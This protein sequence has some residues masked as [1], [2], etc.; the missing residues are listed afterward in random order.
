M[1]GK[2]EKSEPIRSIVDPSFTVTSETLAPKSSSKCTVSACPFSAAICR[3]VMPPSAFWFTTLD[4]ALP[5]SSRRSN[6]PLKE[7]QVLTNLN[8]PLVVIRKR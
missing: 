7:A 2:K 8:I 6:L 4:K 3:A 5:I 1:K